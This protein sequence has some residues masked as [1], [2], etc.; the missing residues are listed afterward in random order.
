[1]LSI[2]NPS[3][4]DQQVERWM[5]QI[6]WGVGASYQAFKPKDFGMILIK[7]IGLVEGKTYRKPLFLM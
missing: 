6:T 4:T 7:F 5:I 2:F 1:V 3:T